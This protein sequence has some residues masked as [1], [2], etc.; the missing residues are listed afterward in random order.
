MQVQ[1]STLQLSLTNVF[2]DKF[3]RGI[4]RLFASVYLKN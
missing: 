1:I 3:C 4:K 2:T